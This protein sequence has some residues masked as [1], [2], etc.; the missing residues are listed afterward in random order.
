MF[1]LV[2]G[3]GLAALADPRWLALEEA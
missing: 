1:E 3:R 2:P